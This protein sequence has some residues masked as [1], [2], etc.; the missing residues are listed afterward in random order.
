MADYARFS[1]LALTERPRC[2]FS[3]LRFTAAIFLAVK[4]PP[5]TAY[6]LGAVPLSPE[7]IPPC[8][9]LNFKG[10]V[11]EQEVEKLLATGEAQQ[12]LPEKEIASSPEPVLSVT[13]R[14][15]GLLALTPALWF[16]DPL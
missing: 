1:N 2:I 6:A 11:I 12:S 13:K 15:R 14:R 4:N 5:L 8:S 9:R 16:S 7:D 10:I 3:F